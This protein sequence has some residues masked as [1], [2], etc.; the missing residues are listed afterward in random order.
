[1]RPLGFMYQAISSWAREL[2]KTPR[3]L[4]VGGT[5]GLYRKGGEAALLSHPGEIISLSLKLL[6]WHFFGQFSP[7]IAYPN[8][9][10]YFVSLAIG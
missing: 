4:T 6:N 2:E 1:M 10:A 5:A 3:N 9:K 8:S 7:R